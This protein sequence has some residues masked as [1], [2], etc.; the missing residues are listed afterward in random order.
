MGITEL[1][2]SEKTCEL[3]Q[4]NANPSPP[5][6]LPTSL[7]ATSPWVLNTSSKRVGMGSSCRCCPCCWVCSSRVFLHH[8]SRAEPPR[9][10]KAV[11]E[12]PQWQ[13]N[14][15]AWECTSV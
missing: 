7:C 3:I 9:G 10:D 8:G 6:P 5:C 2:W 13:E 1:L 15:L 11:Y 4:Y 12:V 14:P